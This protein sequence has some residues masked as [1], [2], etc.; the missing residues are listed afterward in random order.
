MILNEKTIYINFVDIEKLW[1]FV[2]D[3]CFIWV[4]LIMQNHVFIWKF[5][6]FKWPQMEKLPK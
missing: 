2:V 6:F 5:E 3:N 4:H 1:N